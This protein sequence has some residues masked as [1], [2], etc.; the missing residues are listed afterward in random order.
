MCIEKIISCTMALKNGSL[1]MSWKRI[2]WT[3]WFA[4]FVVDLLVGIW[5][6]Y[7]TLAGLDLAKAGLII[8]VSGFLGDGSQLFFGFLGDKGYRKRL[9]ILGVILVIC[10]GFF[11]FTTNYLLLFFLVLLTYFGSGLFH[12]AAVGIAQTLIPGR[13]GFTMTLFASGGYVGLALAQLLF[14]SLYRITPIASTLLILFVFIALLMTRSGLNIRPQ[15]KSKI[16]FSVKKFFEPFQI[17]K[18]EITLLYFSQLAQQTISYA[19]IFFLPDILLLQNQTPWIC[20]GGGH[21]FYIMG[22]GIML[23]PAGILSDRFGQ[24]RILLFSVFASCILFYLFLFHVVT[25][26]WFVP[27]FLF[28]FGSCMGVYNPIGVALG[29]KL[30][31]THV[32]SMSALLMGCVWCISHIVGAAGGGLLTKCFEEGAPIKAMLLLGLLFPL[33]FALALF[34]P[35]KEK[36]QEATF[37]HTI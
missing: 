8:G 29:N 25:L 34:L 37:S 26:A 4:H 36:V 24:K 19:F 22:A 33:S 2:L 23:I 3:V 6:A 15:E 13:K 7:K 16:K 27:L 30:L 17:K 14:A 10:S 20:Y 9:L 12:P 31:P 35:S 32:S 28:I 11:V 18:K 5:P 21:C 1:A